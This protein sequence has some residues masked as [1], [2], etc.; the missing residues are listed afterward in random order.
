MARK[1]ITTR[2]STTKTTRGRKPQKFYT[3]STYLFTD[4][5]QV[6][7]QFETWMD[8]GTFNKNTQIFEVTGIHIWEKQPRIVVDEGLAT[9]KAVTCKKKK[10]CR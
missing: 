6:S 3:V 10:A 4:L 8:E 9:L 2:K 1:K 5:K 7:K